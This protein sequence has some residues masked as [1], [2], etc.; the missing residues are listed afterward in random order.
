MLEKM[1]SNY[2]GIKLEPALGTQEDKIEHLSSYA[3][4]VHTTAKLVKTSSK[5][6]KIKNARA[7]RAKILLS[8]VKFANLWGF[9]CRRRGGCLSSLLACVNDRKK[10]EQKRA[11]LGA[12]FSK[13]SLSS[14]FLGV[15][16]CAPIPLISY[17]K[18]SN[19]A[20]LLVFLT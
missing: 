5:C 10:Y 9:C 20:I 15:Y 19:F 8:I 3:H 13:V 2:L 11:G 18:P 7:K 1:C 14:N 12:C 6:Q 16:S 17:P 4:V